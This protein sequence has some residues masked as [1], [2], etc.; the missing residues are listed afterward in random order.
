MKEKCPFCG[1]AMH[2]TKDKIAICENDDCATMFN[3]WDLPRA[4]AAM[5][6][7]VATTAYFTVQTEE[8]RERLREAGQATLKIFRGEE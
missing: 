1:D 6:L 7:A 2:L 5:N 4:I 3:E 8:S